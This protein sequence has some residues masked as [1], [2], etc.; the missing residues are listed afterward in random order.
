MLLILEPNCGLTVKYNDCTFPVLFGIDSDK[1]STF[2]WVCTETGMQDASKWI[3]L[4]WLHGQVF[5][6]GG[7]GVCVTTCSQVTL[8]G[9]RPH[10]LLWKRCLRVKKKM[11]HIISVAM[12]P[13][14]W[15]WLPRKT[16]KLAFNKTKM[17]V[18]T[19]EEMGCTEGLWGMVWCLWGCSITIP[20]QG[21]LATFTYDLSPHYPNLSAQYS[22]TDKTW[23]DR[24][25]RKSAS[26]LMLSERFHLSSFY[27]RLNRFLQC[28]KS[29]CKA[30]SFTVVSWDRP[31]HL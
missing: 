27:S 22:A 2:S 10:R 18:P 11:P 14:L 29:E 4:C 7:G 9:Q 20:C 31:L 6:L 26:A 5:S 15:V 30:K 21:L 3:K 24:E 25:R 13:F 16:S 17:T 12:T 28:L 8:T 19:R 1:C 23:R